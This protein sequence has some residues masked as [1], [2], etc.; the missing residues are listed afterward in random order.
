MGRPGWVKGVE[1][2]MRPAADAVPDTVKFWWIIAGGVFFGAM[3]LTIQYFWRS[4]FPPDNEERQKTPR[5]SK[6]FGYNDNRG[7]CAKYFCCCCCGGSSNNTQ[8]KQKPIKGI[9]ADRTENLFAT[10]S[11]RSLYGAEEDDLILAQPAIELGPGYAPG[12]NMANN[13]QESEIRG[14]AQQTSYIM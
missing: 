10:D 9:T 12:E 11:S 8:K 5:R 13:L 6:R 4:M 3:L 14:S 7:C 2:F 1:D